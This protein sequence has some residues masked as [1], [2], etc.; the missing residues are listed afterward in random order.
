MTTATTLNCAHASGW[1]GRWEPDTG[2]L[3]PP[4]AGATR[5]DVALREGGQR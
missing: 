3:A 1:T 2:G 5:G 4:R